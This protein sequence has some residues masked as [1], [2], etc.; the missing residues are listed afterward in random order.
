MKIK[1]KTS[2]GLRG[3]MINELRFLIDNTNNPKILEIL[4]NIAKLP[5]DKQ[6]LAF[7]QYL[8]DK[9]NDIPYC[10][11]DKY[12]YVKLDDKQYKGKGEDDRCK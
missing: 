1:K 3:K 12:G 10:G 6:V 8:D 9:A 5:E 4:V 7:K 11:H 2:L